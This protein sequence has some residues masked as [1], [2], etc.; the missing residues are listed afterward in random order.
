MMPTQISTADPATDIQAP[1]RLSIVIPTYNGRRL[2]EPCLESVMQHRPAT[3]EVIVVDDASTDGTAEEIAR[4]WPE[5]RLVRLERNGGFCRTVNAGLEVCQGEVVE[6]LNNDTEVTEGWTEAPMAAFEDPSVG[7]V[8][9]LVCKLPHRGV[10]DSAGDQYFWFGMA[11]KRGEGK[12][13]TDEFSEATDVFGASASSAFYRLAALKVIGGF[14]EHFTA[15]LDDVDVGFRLRLAG[16]RCRFE[17]KSR[18]FHWVSQSHSLGSRRMKHQVA[19]ND[20]RVFWSN[21]T[22]KELA[23]HAAPHFAFL[24]IQLAYKAIRGDFGPWF[25]GK[26]AAMGEIGDLIGYRRAA[27][28][29]RRAAA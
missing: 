5:V 14:P 20:E 8:A 16:Y 18:V 6:L 2:L 26:C 28:R 1:V 27:Q 3:A 11:K 24:L 17:P 19:R 13:V 23:M 7:S 22:P 4:R 15:Y 9:P 25:A 29:L 21:L 10:I 12:P